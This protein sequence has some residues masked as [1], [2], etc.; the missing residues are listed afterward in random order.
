MDF[1]YGILGHV[2][3]G[4]RFELHRRPVSDAHWKTDV[5]DIHLQGKILMLKTL[6]KDERETRTDFRPVPGGTTLAGAKDLLDAATSEA[7]SASAQARLVPV[8]AR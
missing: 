1:G 7:L 2:D 3:Q 4:G 8:A 5:V 6:T